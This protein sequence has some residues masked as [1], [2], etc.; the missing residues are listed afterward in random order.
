[1]AAAIGLWAY[2][3]GRRNEPPAAQPNGL[4]PKLEDAKPKNVVPATAAAVPQ[5]L[6]DRIPAAG[7]RLELEGRVSAVAFSPDGKWFAAAGSGPGAGTSVWNNTGQLVAR[8]PTRDGTRVLSISHDG[9]LIAGDLSGRVRVWA[10]PSGEQEE[11]I[12]AFPTANISTVAFHPDGRRIA[13]GAIPWEGNA[14]SVKMNL[15]LVA[16][17]GAAPRDLL[18]HEGGIWSLAF[19]PDGSRLASTARDGTVR[20][21]NVDSGAAEHVLPVGRNPQGYSPSVGY[22]PDGTLV[23]G[24]TARVQFY[25]PDG[26]KVGE[27]WNIRHEI[28]ALACSST[29]LT[30]V[31]TSDMR[32]RLWS[33]AERRQVRN[34]VVDG[35]MGGAA[36]S[37]DGKLLLAGSS[38]R[39]A[40]LWDMRRIR[41]TP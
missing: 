29:G 41:E 15:K 5:E 12:P 20:V 9:R 39:A 21:W 4:R 25:E 10:L 23:V 7:L 24:A 6:L 38:H 2:F 13:V 40:F 1:V 27:D 8:I 3:D 26:K 30:A 36:F 11:A 18:G 33:T 31:F 22:L 32:A 19:S 34:F 16:R 28:T 14:D 37:P 35:D 17:G